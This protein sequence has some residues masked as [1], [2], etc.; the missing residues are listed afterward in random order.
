MYAMSKP[1]NV[2]QGSPGTRDRETESDEPV[3][4]R[5]LLNLSNLRGGDYSHFHSE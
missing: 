4:M 1:I 5:P 3:C 2:V